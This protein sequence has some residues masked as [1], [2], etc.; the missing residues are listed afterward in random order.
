MPLD[1]P[2]LRIALY[3]T[4]FIFS[5]V[6]FG[7]SGARLHYTTHLPPGDPLNNGT[8]FYDPIVAELLVTTLFAMVWSIFLIHTIHKRV[9]NR[10][11]Y[12]FRA[13]IVG[14]C[15]L[16]LMW[17]VGAAVATSIWGD[18]S[19]CQQFRA[20]RLLTALVA[21]SWMGWIILTTILAISI[22]FSFANRAWVEPMHG[23]WD[24]RASIW[25]SSRV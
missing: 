5:L 7:L 16:W 2:P 6:L 25:R 15:I 22:L 18:L 9:E 23:R 21:F 19:F 3:A 8:N 11:V 20:C 10:W 12:T 4:L 14:L 1:L 17:L 24:P 13:E